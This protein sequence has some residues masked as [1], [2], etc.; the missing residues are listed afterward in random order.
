[1]IYAVRFRWIIEFGLQKKKRNSQTFLKSVILHIQIICFVFRWC[2]QPLWVI[3][4]LF[5]PN[6]RTW[7]S[8]QASR[9]RWSI[10]ACCCAH[11]FLMW[12]LFFL[13]LSRPASTVLFFVFFFLLFVSLMQFS[14]CQ[15]GLSFYFT[16]FVSHLCSIVQRPVSNLLHKTKINVSM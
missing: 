7:S 11:S 1:M 9:P 13:F 6:Q 3:E 5:S 16:T 8:W 12:F 14:C 10:S 15:S 4:P 2:T